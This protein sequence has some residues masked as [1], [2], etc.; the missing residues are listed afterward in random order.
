MTEVLPGQLV[1]ARCIGCGARNRDGD[2]PEGCSDLPLDLVD[3]ADLQALSVA[4]EAREARIAALRELAH[5]LTG[6]APVGWTALQERARAALQLPAPELP[7]LELIQ[8]WGCPRCG[9]IDAPQPCLGI[10]V[11]RPGTVVDVR[12]YRRLA[13]RAERAAA[14]DQALAGPARLL[15]TV[16]PRPGREDAC[17][18]AL[19]ARAHHVLPGP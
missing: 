7:H 13:P 17:I 6:S 10:C 1:V 15:L 3:G 2:C 5:M 8:A 16:T 19:R 11:R 14:A 12:D 4:I 18:T 9:R